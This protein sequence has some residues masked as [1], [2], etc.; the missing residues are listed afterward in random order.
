[1]G[2]VTSFVRQSVLFAFALTV[3]GCSLGPPDIVGFV[4]DATLPSRPSR[5]IGDAFEAAFPGGE[6]SPTMTGMGEMFADYK[7]MAPAE[8]LK[9]LTGAVDLKSCADGV[10]SPCRVPVMFQ[11]FLSSD[12]KTAELSYIQVGDRVIS[13]SSVKA[14]LDF[15]YR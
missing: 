12:N 2:A 14:M 3:A 4:K 9:P 10:Q 15:V 1:L 8:K 11:F 13:G 5:P 6:W 7:V